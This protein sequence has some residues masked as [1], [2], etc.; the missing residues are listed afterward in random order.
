MDKERTRMPPGTSEAT[1]SSSDTTN[2]YPTCARC[3]NHWL[4]IRVKG[5][6][7]YCKYRDCTCE[8]CT[9]IAKSQ[10]YTALQTSVWRAQA[11]DEA[12]AR[13]ASHCPEEG[14]TVT[15]RTPSELD[16]KLMERIRN[17]LGRTQD[18]APVV[19][20]TDSRLAEGS[21]SSLPAG[22]RTLSTAPE[23]DSR[24]PD[25]SSDSLYSAHSSTAGTTQPTASAAPRI[26]FRVM[27]GIGY[28]LFTGG[29]TLL[30]AP[31][32]T[33]PTAPVATL[34]TSPGASAIDSQAI[35]KNDYPFAN[36]SRTLLTASVS[37]AAPSTD[38][39]P[40][41]GCFY[42]LPAGGRILPPVPV[43]DL[44]LV[45]EARKALYSSLSSTTGGTL[46]IAPIA[47]GAP[48]MDSRSTDGNSYSLPT[49][50]RTFPNAPI[51]PWM[52]STPMVGGGC[53]EPIG[54][55][56]LPTASNTKANPSP[57][58]LWCGQGF[59]S[60]GSVSNVYNDMLLNQYYLNLRYLSKP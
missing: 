10:K 6:K 7:R 28:S 15:H 55:R 31:V 34:P 53:T 37:S 23:R 38:S 32:A 52:D 12:L 22:S 14:V 2:S 47:S 33:R 16:S 42:S 4:K 5:H 51:A 54:G 50:S 8:K 39:R 57:L 40:L 3:R 43:T 29:R 25:E 30:T 9:L 1:A 49:G 26:D 46:P 56:P 60:R 27:E 45:E 21:N 13:Q 11:Q 18:T 44:F 20:G 35:E 59:P 17:F 41:D 58:L 48:L 19:P 36:G 24:S